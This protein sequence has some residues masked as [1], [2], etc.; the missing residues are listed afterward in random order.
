MVTYCITKMTTM[1]SSMIR[2]FFEN[3]IVAS[4]DNGYKRPIKI[5]LLKTVL[6][7]L[8]TKLPKQDHLEPSVSL[9]DINFDGFSSAKLYQERISRVHLVMK[10]IYNFPEKSELPKFILLVKINSLF[11]CGFQGGNC[12]DQSRF[13]FSCSRVL[14]LQSEPARRLS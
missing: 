10:N 4:S 3:M 9:V 14:V 11:F 6:S 7:H 8:K 5:H 1:C 13:T 2:Q 12:S